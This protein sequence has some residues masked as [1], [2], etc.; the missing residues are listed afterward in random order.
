MNEKYRNLASPLSD[1][2]T[3]ELEYSGTYENPGYKPK[4]SVVVHAYD[5]GNTLAN[6]NGRDESIKKI[7]G[8]APDSN[9]KNLVFADQEATRKISQAQEKG[10]LSG[11]IAVCSLD[12]VISHLEKEKSRGEDSVMITVGTYQMARSLLHGAGLSEYVAALVTSEEAGSG[13][14][15]TVDVFVRTYDSLRAKGRILE[16]YCDDSEADAKAAVEASRIAES[17]Y[18]KG[19]T[20]YLV[21]KNA[22]DDALGP[23]EKGYFVIRSIAEK[24]EENNEN[25]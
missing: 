25:R 4:G 1:A 8:L 6:T 7:L 12:G 14:R 9:I 19:F 15:K 23:N 22:S 17:R 24:D 2:G 20:V 13:N 3:L 5:I 16:T 21:K 10:I 18:G 11:E